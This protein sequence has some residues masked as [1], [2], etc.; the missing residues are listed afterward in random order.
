MRGKSRGIAP[1]FFAADKSRKSA[2]PL[3]FSHNSRVVDMVDDDFQNSAELDDTCLCCS[4]DCCRPG[5]SPWSDADIQQSQSLRK[6]STQDGT[7]WLGSPAFALPRR[8]VTAAQFD[9]GATFRP[10]CWLRTQRLVIE[11]L[12]I[13]TPA[14]LFAVLLN[15]FIYDLALLGFFWEST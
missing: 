3:H 8:A 7:I 15:F 2:L 6:S 9:E 12:R 10:S 1:T 5:A 13:I 4:C 14:F 11:F